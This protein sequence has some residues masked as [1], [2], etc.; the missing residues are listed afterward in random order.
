MHLYHHD[1]DSVEDLL[2]W[3]LLTQW[4]KTI[5]SDPYVS[6]LLGSQHKQNWRTNPI[7]T[8]SIYHDY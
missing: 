8:E 5:D 7:T 2:L 3:P 6:A 4:R 1:T